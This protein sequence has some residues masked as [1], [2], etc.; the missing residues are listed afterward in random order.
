LASLDLSKGTKIAVFAPL[1]WLILPTQGQKRAGAAYRPACGKENLPPPTKSYCQRRW[2]WLACP[3]YLDDN[4]FPL[5]DTYTA[6]EYRLG[7]FFVR[8]GA[9]IL[10]HP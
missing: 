2:L 3:G 1:L 7:A 9:V 10:L 5:D 4:C 6:W 8:E